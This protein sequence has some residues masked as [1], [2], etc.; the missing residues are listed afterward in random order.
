MI[1]LADI[2]GT[3]MRI[4][5]MRD[6]SSFDDPIIADTPADYD[7]GIASISETIQSLADGTSVEKIVAGVPGILR[8]D[9]RALYDA[10]HLLKWSGEELA[11]DLERKFST[12]VLLE[13]DTALV[14]LGE[15]T[16]GA[17]MGGH[18]VMYVTISTGVNG[19]RVSNGVIDDSTS[20]F[21]IGRQ[22]LSIDTGI[23]LEGLVSG[24]AIEQRFGQHPRDLGKEHFVWEE[25]AEYLA[26]G[27]Y[28]SF[29]HWSPDTI[30]LGGSM[31]NEIGIPLE[32]TAK[33]LEKLL[34]A[35]PSTPRVVHSTLGEVGGL[36]GALQKA[37]Q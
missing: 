5:R 33:H 24:T 13:N 12:R 37:N 23:T 16:F 21:E 34:H 7:A 25:L 17:G 27:L 36:Y 18:I 15:A 19:V 29:L 22:I 30:V 8:S 6:A 35:F 3:K 9:K 28:N 26:Y 14:G 2:G 20:G 11:D 32:S 1:I 10:P 31:C 4:T